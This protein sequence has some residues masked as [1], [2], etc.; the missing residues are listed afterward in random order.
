MAKQSGNVRKG[1]QRPNTASSSIPRMPRVGRKATYDDGQTKFVI[2][3]TGSTNNGVRSGT[4]TLTNPETNQSRNF[5]YGANEKASSTYKRL[6]TYLNS[7]K[8]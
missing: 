3:R 5:N 7:R 1:Y 8:R 6:S 4:F 2:S